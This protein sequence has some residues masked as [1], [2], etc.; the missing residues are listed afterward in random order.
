MGGSS[1]RMIGGLIQHIN[2][3]ADL[4]SGTMVLITADNNDGTAVSSPVASDTDSKTFA[5]PVNT[6]S[7]IIVEAVVRVDITVATSEKSPNVYIKIGASSKNF[8]F[9]SKGNVGDGDDIQQTSGAIVFSAAQTAAATIAV[10]LR[11]EADDGIVVECKT[12]HVYGV[13]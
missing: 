5:L 13:V 10:G 6:F 2:D 7:R 9:S 11:T 4:P 12:L 8:P 1:C 3:V